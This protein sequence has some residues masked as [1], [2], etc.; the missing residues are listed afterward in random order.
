MP[1]SEK[2]SYQI[3]LVDDEPSVNSSIRMLLDFDGHSVQTADSGESA[4]TLLQPGRFHLVITDYYMLGM[5]GDELA[6]LIKLRH[7]GMPIIMITAFADVLQES[8]KVKYVVDYLLLKPFS[9]PDLR[10]AI[11]IVM[12]TPP[13]R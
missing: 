6:A 11:E 1:E 4:L 5:K 3:L 10:K 8:G 9:L 2:P 7:P 13:A 12:S